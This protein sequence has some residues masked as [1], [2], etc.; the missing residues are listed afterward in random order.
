MS[1]EKM[2]LCATMTYL[3][4]GDDHANDRITSKA[5]SVHFV[6]RPLTEKVFDDKNELPGTGKSVEILVDDFSSS[7]TIALVE[8]YIDVDLAYGPLLRRIRKR[9]DM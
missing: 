5:A 3:E 9:S 8:G 6:H 4:E 2:D 1:I 7:N